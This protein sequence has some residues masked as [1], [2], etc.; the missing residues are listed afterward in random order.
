MAFHLQSRPSA[1]SDAAKIDDLL[2][3]FFGAESVDSV[4]LDIQDNE[5]VYRINKPI[6][7][8]NEELL[9]FFKSLKKL[10][11]STAEYTPHF[12]QIHV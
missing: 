7:S 9:E 1:A 10:F 6:I 8:S 4:D 12:T 3:R 2:E 11:E 5:I